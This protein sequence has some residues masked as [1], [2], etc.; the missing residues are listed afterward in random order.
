M[1]NLPLCIIIYRSLA[2]FSHTRENGNRHE[3]WL[4]KEHE[5]NPYSSFPQSVE[6]ESRHRPCENRELYKGIGFP[7]SRE[8]LDSGLRPA[9]MTALMEHN[10]RIYKF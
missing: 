4:T 2:N 10:T 8:T 1:K 5:N 7:F 9:G 3:Q 6:R